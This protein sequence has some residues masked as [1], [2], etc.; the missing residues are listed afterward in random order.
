MM[1]SR[2]SGQP[3]C[4]R[5]WIVFFDAQ[6]ARDTRL[7]VTRLAAALFL[8]SLLLPIGASAAEVPDQGVWAGLEL[9]VGSVRRTTDTVH[10]ESTVHMAF[11]GGYAFSEHL[12]LGMEIGGETQEAGDLWDPSEGEGISQVLVIGQFYLRPTRAGWYAKGGGGYVSYWN[13]TPSGLEDSG[14]GVTLGLGYDWRTDGFG[15][16]GPFASFGYGKAGA[17]DHQAISLSLS[18]SFP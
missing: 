3:D 12:L 2:P 10:T 17:I 14:W 4:R 9:G 15:T 16:I 18:W 8:V 1:I 11:K 13:N 7:V 5:A 6:I